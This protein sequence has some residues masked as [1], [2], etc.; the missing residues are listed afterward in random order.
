MPVLLDVK[1]LCEFKICPDRRIR[2]SLMGGEFEL[3]SN[4]WTITSFFFFQKL[5]HWGY[6]YGRKTIL[7]VSLRVDSNKWGAACVRFC[8]IIE[9]FDWVILFTVLNTPL[10][11]GSWKQSYPG[12]VVSIKIVHS[13]LKIICRWLS[14]N[15]S[16][17]TKQ[18]L[19]YSITCEKCMIS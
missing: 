16:G 9:F 8:L 18:Q 3:K 6:A 1:S 17:T 13:I 14:W 4:D 5:F 10:R 15:S 2:S 11:W 7:E 12:P 19:V